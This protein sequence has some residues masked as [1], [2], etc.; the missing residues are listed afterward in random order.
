MSAHS[1]ALD[2]PMIRL[3]LNT[4]AVYEDAVGRY[5]LMVDIDG[6]DREDWQLKA[7]R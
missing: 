7:P 4:P 5:G 3:D 2:D 6:Q 1:Y